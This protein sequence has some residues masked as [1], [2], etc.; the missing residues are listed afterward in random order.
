MNSEPHT[1]CCSVSV[2]TWL[3]S[4]GF[5]SVYCIFF[6]HEKEIYYNGYLC[7]E[8]KCG[9]SREHYMEITYHTTRQR[10]ENIILV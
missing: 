9:L 5:K 7:F 10:Y 1:G 2:A 6:V 8:A 3:R 4:Q